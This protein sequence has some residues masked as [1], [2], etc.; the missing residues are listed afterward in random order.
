MTLTLATNEAG[1][2]VITIHDNG[3]GIEEAIRTKIFD[4]FF[5]TKTTSEAA[6]VGLY[7]AR[8]VV[9]AHHGTMEL[10]PQIPGQTDF[11]ITL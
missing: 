11:I 5:T 1:K 4:P 2:A 8:E 3:I 7:L 10:G 9:Q 6:G